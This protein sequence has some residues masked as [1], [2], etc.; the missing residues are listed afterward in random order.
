MLRLTNRSL[1]L[2][3]FG[4]GMAV[5]TW[6]GLKVADRVLPYSDSKN[7]IMDAAFLPGA[8]FAT[9]FFREGIHTGT[10]TVMWW[11]LAAGTNCILYFL[12][13]Y[14]LGLVCRNI[15]S[16]TRFPHRNKMIR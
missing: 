11:Y 16:R 12:F 2:V 3:L 6:L 9:I 8:W 7:F 5:L 14:M 10:G 4:A 13:W 1:R 15:L